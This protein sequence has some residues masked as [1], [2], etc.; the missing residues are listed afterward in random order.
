MDYR[1]TVFLAVAE[2]I[3]FSKAAEE[4]FIS[5]PAVTQHIKTLENRLNISLFER[6]GNKIHLTQAGQLTYHYL[7]RI[8]H[9]YNELEFELGRLNDT[10][11]GTLRIGASQQFH[12]IQYHP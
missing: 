4:L 6:K 1:D 8:K 11:K 2:N 12:N 5:Q 9:Q 10:F 3:S 7:K